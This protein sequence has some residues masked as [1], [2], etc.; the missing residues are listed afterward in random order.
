M[1][2]PLIYFSHFMTV[3]HTIDRRG[4]PSKGNLVHLLDLAVAF[5]IRICLYQVSRKEIA[6]CISYSSPGCHDATRDLVNKNND[7]I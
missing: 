5:L 4:R 1:S 7:V 3:C 6:V 2:R